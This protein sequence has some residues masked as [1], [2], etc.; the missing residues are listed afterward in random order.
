MSTTTSVL[1][2]LS[3]AEYDHAVAAGVF[4]D[5]ARIELVDGELHAMTPEGTRHTTAIDLASSQLA[6]IFHTNAYLRI[7]HPLATGDD[8]E[9]EPDIAVVNGTIRDYEDAHPT[10]AL[11]IVEVSDESLERDRTVKQRLYARCGI[12]EYWI[13][14]IPERTLEVYRDAGNDDYK[15]IT[16][17]IA[18]DTVSPLARPEAV[19]DVASLLPRRR[20][21]G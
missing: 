2:R 11:L 20:Q 10:S 17:Y 13:I 9:P 1:Y 14:A 5:K 19:M 18:G 6:R 4:G 7:Q 8:S 3:R 21:L 12:G 15:A 16:R